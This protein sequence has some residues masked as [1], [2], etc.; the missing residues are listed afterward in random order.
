QTG[1]LFALTDDGAGNWTSVAL[2]VEASWE[3][4]DR[5]GHELSIAKNEIDATYTVLVGAPGDD[6]ENNGQPNRGLVVMYETAL[7]I[8][9]NNLVPVPVLS[10]HVNA[11]DEYGQSVAID[12][13][14]TNC[15]I[16][17]WKHDA[18]PGSF[19]EGAVALFSFAEAFAGVWEG[20]IDTDWTNPGNWSDGNVPNGNTSVTIAD[21]APNMPVLNTLGFC[22][23]LSLD[24][25]ETL[26]LDGQD[27]LLRVN[28]DATILGE[29]IIPEGANND[30]ATLEVYGDFYVFC[31][32][33]KQLPAGAYYGDLEVEASS[34]YSNYLNQAGD[35]YSYGRLY[36]QNRGKLQI[37][38]H[39][40]ELHDYISGSSNGGLHSTLESDLKLTGEPVIAVNLS[41]NIK[42]I[43]NLTV[44]NVKGVNKIMN[45]SL[46]I[47]GT[48]NLVSGEF[49][50][51]PE[52]AGGASLYLY[53]SMIGNDALLVTYPESSL[54]IEGELENIQLPSSLTTLTTLGIN[55]P[56]NV[57]LNSNVFVNFILWL[58]SGDIDNNGFQ[59]GFGPTGEYWSGSDAVIQDDFLDPDNPPSKIWVQAGGSVEVDGVAEVEEL[60]VDGGAKAYNKDEF[61]KSL[62]R[63][64]ISE[65]ERQQ[66][67]DAWEQAAKA[68]REAGGALTIRPIKGLT[69]TYTI[70]VGGSLT[71]KSSLAGNA[72]FIDNTNSATAIQA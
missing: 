45:G 6:G 57:R 34:A 33:D 14:G 70:D 30:L 62:S 32:K 27:A 64:E 3:N 69:V 31:E 5:Y 71:L 40:L 8:V 7:P 55:N 12:V 28:G 67:V 39:Y 11:D 1:K 59:I 24:Q 43:N 56:N 20:T 29:L 50:V 26:T 19:K 48:L 63:L 58:V 54:W 61:A 21:D 46:H 51:R 41:R 68:G 53:N 10:G 35:V 52:F 25:N 47:H 44:D 66:L 18:V 37:G 65:V 36:L 60:D 13:M 22:L 42:K 38:P 15:V 2:N 16:G 17:A 72:S 23:N 4:S 9:A 49:K